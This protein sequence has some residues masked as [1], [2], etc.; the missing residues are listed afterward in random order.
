MPYFMKFRHVIEQKAYEI[1]NELRLP[2]IS[3]FLEGYVHLLQT[4]SLALTR[5]Y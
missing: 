3:W 4:S 1:V 5:L 2:F